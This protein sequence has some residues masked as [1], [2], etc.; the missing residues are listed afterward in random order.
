MT[1]WGPPRAERGVCKTRRRDATNP[2]AREPAAFEIER[3]HEGASGYYGDE[4]TNVPR[5]ANDVD[6][7]RLI[8]EA[9]DGNETA[10]GRLLE[11][12]RNYLRL[13]ARLEIGRRLQGKLDASDLVQ[14][15]F[16]EAHRN[17]ALFRGQEE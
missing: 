15:T 5:P 1:E 6:P 12:Y 14:E 8:Q 2:T 11:L 4:G 13:L 9:R 10:L 17:F 3:R 16:T 7:D